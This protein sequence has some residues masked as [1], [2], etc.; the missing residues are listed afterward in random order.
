MQAAIFGVPAA[1]FDVQ[2]V[3]HSLPTAS[4]SDSDERPQ[5]VELEQQ[6]A[7]LP[8]MTNADVRSTPSANFGKVC[9]LTC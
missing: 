1:L 3:S 7:Q 5:V 2:P 4:G 8:G 9:C 6:P